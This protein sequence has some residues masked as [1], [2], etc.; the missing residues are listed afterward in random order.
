MLE[1]RRWTVRL[2]LKIDQIKPSQHQA[3]D[4]SFAPVDNMALV[5]LIHAYI[6]F[7]IQCHGAMEK[8]VKCMK[9]AKGKG[10]KEK[11]HERGPHWWKCPRT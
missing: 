4:R 9:K 8:F 7:N 2:D 3:I 5:L 1:I 10:G 11:G 6:R